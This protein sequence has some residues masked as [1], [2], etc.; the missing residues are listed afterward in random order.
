MGLHGDTQLM[1]VPR[2]SSIKPE[3]DGSV[4]IKLRA[5]LHEDITLL[6]LYF[7]KNCR[8]PCFQL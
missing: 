3:K 4:L 6:I 8:R 1:F 2:F 7:W 5:F